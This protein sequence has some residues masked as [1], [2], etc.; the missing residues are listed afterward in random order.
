[1]AAAGKREPVHRPGNLCFQRLT[2]RVE[3]SVR[4]VFIKDLN[5]AAWHLKDT[6]VAL[7][8]NHMESTG[9]AIS[10]TVC[11]TDSIQP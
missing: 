5:S 3:Q 9:H 11:R 2:Y 6:G 7:R 8:S 1:M 4:G 10:S